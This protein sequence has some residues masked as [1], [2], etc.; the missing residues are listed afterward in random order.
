MSEGRKMS[1]LNECSHILRL[2]AVD[3]HHNH[4]VYLY[5]FNWK[6]VGTFLIYFYRVWA[7]RITRI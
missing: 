3:T 7:A 2:L 4:R 6:I 5:K 1:K